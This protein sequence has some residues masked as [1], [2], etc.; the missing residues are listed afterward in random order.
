MKDEKVAHG[1]SLRQQ[2]HD[3]LKQMIIDGEFEPGEHLVETDLSD[4]LGVSRG[5]IRE[6]LN[7]LQT[8]GLVD[9]RPRQGAFIHEPSQ[10]EIDDFYEV[11]DLLESEVMRRVSGRL[12]PEHLAYLRDQIARTRAAIDVHDEAALLRAMAEFHGYIHR[13]AGNPILIDLVSSLD[14]RLRW[15]HPLS[16]DRSVA[17]WQ[18]HEALVEALAVG[19]QALAVS[20]MRAHNSLTRRA[21]INEQ[22][23]APEQNIEDEP[24][25]T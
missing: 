16:L 4:R 12:T 2:V 10:E 14:E 1:P 22:L 21:Y 6:A 11:R 13:L 24:L 7:Q 9:L 20:I 5:P 17:A 19:D 18:E 25:T 8:E 15:Y 3:R 23:G